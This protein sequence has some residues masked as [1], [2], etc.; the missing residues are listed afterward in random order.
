MPVPVQIFSGFLGAGKTTAIRAQLE[1]R[2]GER[3]AVIVNDFGEAG[4]DQEVLAEGEPFRITNIPGGCVCCTAPEGFVDALGAV[5]EQ[6]PDR[7]IIEP[8]GLARPQDLI[9]TIRRCPHAEALELAPVVVLVDPRLIGVEESSALLRQQVQAADVL[10]AN[11][12]DLASRNEIAAFDRYAAHLWPAPLAVVHTEH[13]VLPQQKLDWPAGEGPRGELQ[14]EHAPHDA[15]STEGHHA[16]SWRWSP[17]AVFSGRR[18]RDALSALAGDPAVARFKG[19][20]RTE[21]GVSR[22]EIAGGVLHDRLTSFR[23]DSRCDLIARGSS[24]VLDTVEA[25]LAAAVLRNEELHRD[26]NRIEFV[27]PDGRVHLVDRPELIALP[28]GIPDVSARFPKR[29]GAAARLD[30]LFETLGL[31]GS[32]SAVVVAGD[33]FASEPVSIAVLRQGVLLHS[34]GDAPLPVDQGGPF[35]LLIPQDASPDSISCANVKGVAK[36]VVRA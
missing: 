13:G 7:L 18:L 32:G 31:S 29:S 4:F 15:P 22:L 1:A 20:F 24:Q 27:L 16:R 9:D 17:E 14:H 36:I 11:R 21:E 10:V 6:T 19:I 2:K 33:G 35:R 5:L 28:D 26:P 34:L 3:I 23:R 25:A 12:I 30:P 8:T